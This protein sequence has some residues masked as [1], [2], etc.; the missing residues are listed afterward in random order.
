MDVLN[1]IFQILVLCFNLVTNNSN[2]AEIDIL[3]NAKYQGSI[4]F[5]K[6]GNNAKVYKIENGNKTDFCSIRFM[7]N[8]LYEITMPNREPFQVD[9]AS[10]WTQIN[11]Q[12]IVH[13]KQTFKIQGLT[14][15]I[16]PGKANI[17]IYFDANESV[18]VLPLKLI[19][20]N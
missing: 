3:R 12:D 17:Y 20:K 5:I 18:F 16:L 1:P 13:K 4:E 15:T 11:Y 14:I 19:K 7:D 6:E 9:I 10:I 2:V 8:A